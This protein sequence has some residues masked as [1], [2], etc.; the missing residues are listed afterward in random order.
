M[1][2]AGVVA[3]KVPVEDKSMKEA[4]GIILPKGFVDMNIRA[5]EIGRMEA[6][7]K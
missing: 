1:L 7:K 4:I 5:Y 3:G 2:G 6:L